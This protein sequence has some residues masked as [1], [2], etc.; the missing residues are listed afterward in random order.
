MWINKRNEDN[1][2]ENL[3]NKIIS[4]FVLLD[5]SKVFDYT[6]YYGICDIGI[7]Q[8]YIKSYSMNR[9]QIAQVI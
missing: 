4:S 9:T 7:P 2:I 6:E 3:N 5:L 1:I 8:N